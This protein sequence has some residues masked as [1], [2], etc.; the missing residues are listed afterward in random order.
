MAWSLDHCSLIVIWICKLV[1]IPEWLPH[2]IKNFS[3]LLIYL[4]TG[5]ALPFSLPPLDDNQHVFLACPGLQL[6][7]EM[8]LH[9]IS[10]LEASSDY[11]KLEYIALL[12]DINWWK[13]LNMSHNFPTVKTCWKKDVD[14]YVKNGTGIYDWLTF[15]FTC[16]IFQ[17][18]A[19]A[20]SIWWRWHYNNQGD[21]QKESTQC[22]VL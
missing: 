8:H 5:H 10:K 15:P 17:L 18:V 11:L 3:Q 1:S 6:V 4:L 9:H 16:L 14:K 2:C 21:C 12:H 7:T 13:L 20:A 19:S 22:Q